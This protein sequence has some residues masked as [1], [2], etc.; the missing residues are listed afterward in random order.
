MYIHYTDKNTNNLTRLEKKS[1]VELEHT[2]LY[3]Q[4]S[5]NNNLIK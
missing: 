4:E 5:A 2:S 1:L 3:Y